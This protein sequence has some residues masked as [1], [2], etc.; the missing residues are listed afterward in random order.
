MGPTTPTA[1]TTAVAAAVAVVASVLFLR[2]AWP[3][4]ATRHRRRGLGADASQATDATNTDADGDDRDARLARYGNAFPGIRTAGLISYA[5]ILKLAGSLGDAV[6]Q[7]LFGS[8]TLNVMG[9]SKLRWSLTKMDGFLASLPPRWAQ[10][11]GSTA[12]SVTNE[13]HR[14]IRGLLNSAVSKSEITACYHRINEIAK[15]ELA[16]LSAAGHRGASY[17]GAWMLP[18]SQR[19]TFRVISTFVAGADSKHEE[20]IADLREDYL[21]WSK[22][23]ADHTS[24]AWQPFSDFRTAMRARGRIAARIAG[25]VRE[26]RRRLAAGG[27]PAAD[28]LGLL[29]GGSGKA[30]G[31]AG[32]SDVEVVDNV[33]ALLFA[34]YET[35]SSLLST[36][37]HYLTRVLTA[38]QRAQLQAEVDELFDSSDAAGAAVPS[39]RALQALPVLDALLKESL[40]IKTP[41]PGT[42]RRLSKDS[43]IDG[44]PVAAGTVLRVWLQPTM[45]DAAVFPDPDV[46]DLER[47]LPG[48]SA[49]DGS[50][51]QYSYAPFSVGPR[52]CL[53][54]QLARLEFKVLI[55]QM[56]R[57]YTV[58]PGKADS[59]ADLYPFH[60]YSC[61]LLL[62]PKE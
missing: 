30:G 29:I 43:E 37:C 57:N 40:R 17:D 62:T 8:V 36:A 24:S 5:D 2:A 27:E 59:I 9:A 33:V 58:E 50:I 31:D 6:N 55:A 26:R 16:L 10:L 34:G 3:A 41:V 39:E 44:S 52:Q 56:L 14:R 20:V 47:F 15:E 13:G 54:M 1:A 4:I 51:S 22:G 23:L 38:E 48:G 11:I 46:F 7:K 42:W 53:G 18:F 60:R 35:T 21:V 61:S 12:V 28:V 25:I 32:F 49:A 45:L 19:F